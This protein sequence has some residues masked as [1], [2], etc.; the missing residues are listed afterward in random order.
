MQFATREFQDDDE[1]NENDIH[2]SF[3]IMANGFL[4]T[5]YRPVDVSGKKVSDDEGSIEG[6]IK[7][8]IKGGVEGGIKGGTKGIVLSGDLMKLP[9]RQKD[10]LILVVDN[11]K[12][13]IA[14]V[15][16]TLGINRSATQKHFDAL[17]TKKIIGRI[18]YKRGG[19][20][21][22]FVNLKKLGI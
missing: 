2:L 13:S 11:N 6:G 8:G 22:I 1:C 19:Y 3:D 20:W 17:S 15:A 5:F 18:G 10:V 9:S 21:K 12:I 14:A 4:T 7:G 16:K